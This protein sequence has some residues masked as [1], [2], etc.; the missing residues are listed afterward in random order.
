MA[1]NHA[2]D[3]GRR[4][5]LQRAGGGLVAALAAG[6]AR[7]RAQTPTAS[8]LKIGMVGAGR[9]GGAL[10]AVFVKAGHPVMFSGWRDENITGC[11]A[12]TNSSPRAPP[13]RP[14]PTMPILSG[15]AV[16][17]WALARD[18]RAASAS[19]PSPHPASLKKWRRP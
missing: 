16:D 7:A 2:A 14:A 15:G 3:H 17:V 5:F 19:A 8:P 13:M 4:D 11:P 1:G 10:G 9:M 12:F 6:P 18:G